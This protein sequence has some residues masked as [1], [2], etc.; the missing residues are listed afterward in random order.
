M[1]RIAQLASD[2][3]K[4]Q[5]PHSLELEC[6]NKLRQEL[7]H[8]GEAYDNLNDVVAEMGGKFSKHV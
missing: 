5:A 8:M 4:L 3:A 2:L 1:Q 6:G 7:R